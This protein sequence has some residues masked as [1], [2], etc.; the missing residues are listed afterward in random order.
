MDGTSRLR[1]WMV[2]TAATAV[3]VAVLAFLW[4]SQRP[5]FQVIAVAGGPAASP[6]LASLRSQLETIRRYDDQMVTVMTAGIQVV[7]VI[8]LALAAFS[9]YTNNRIY[10]RDL[11][12]VR[13][14]LENAVAVAE[15][16][17]SKD[18]SARAQELHAEQAKAAVTA[19]KQAVAGV[20]NEVQA[21]K[22]DF[23]EDQMDRRDRAAHSLLWDK[24][25]H[26]AFTMYVKAFKAARKYQY[27]WTNYPDYIDSL[28][29]I[30][31]DLGYR[32]T[33]DELREVEECVR[34]LSSDLKPG[35]DGLRAAIAKA[36][37]A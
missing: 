1:P 17:I 14:E 23:W 21:L 4:L 28:T 13:R 25:G 26:E 9:W 20:S 19:A 34:G 18:A 12:A 3:S 27:G 11:D 35:V 33:T 2:L 8:A 31:R 6:E 32:P 16:R 36:A 30:I 24:K 7:V 37:N 5:Q 10:E 29:E 22:D 15:A